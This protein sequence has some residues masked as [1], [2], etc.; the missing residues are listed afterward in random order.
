MNNKIAIDTNI[1][2]Y[3]LDVIFPIKKQ[4]SETL[5][6]SLPTISSQKYKRICKRMS[7]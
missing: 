5:I 4:L 1:L 2:I 3:A 7:A 6:D